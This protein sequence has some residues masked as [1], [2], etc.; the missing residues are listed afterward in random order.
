LPWTELNDPTIGTH[1][2]YREGDRIRLVAAS[3]QEQ[4]QAQITAL[5]RSIDTIDHHLS[6]V[7]VGDP[8]V[9][10]QSCG[11][12]L[13]GAADAKRAA[14]KTDKRRALDQIALLEQQAAPSTLETKQRQT[15]PRK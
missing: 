5:R 1:D 3:E 10:C 4:R 11:Q 6:S 12:P 7:G 14:L 2:H 15:Q 9:S 13:K 8:S